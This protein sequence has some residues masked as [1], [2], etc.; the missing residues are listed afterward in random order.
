MHRVVKTGLVAWGLLGSLSAAGLDILKEKWQEIRNEDGVQV[1]E[2]SASADGLIAF[3]SVVTVNHP[4]EEALGFIAD[5]QRKPDWVAM[6]SGAKLLYNGPY[7]KIVYETY[8]FPF[9]ISDRDVVYH[10]DVQPTSTGVVINVHSV[11]DSGAPPTIGERMHLERSIVY[12]HR[13]GPN[14]TRNETYIL[15]SPGGWI[16]HWLVNLLNKEEVWKGGV[17]YRRFLDTLAGIVPLAV[18]PGPAVTVSA[19]E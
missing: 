8:D 14:Q 9:P 12:L 16:P 1:F 10:W 18:P 11:T 2:G 3:K 4:L 17:A 5:L 13:V 15:A 19:V 6:Q 7:E